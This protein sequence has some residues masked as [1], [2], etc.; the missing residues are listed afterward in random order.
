MDS[1]KRLTRSTSDRMIA[2]VAGGLA[3]YFGLDPVL[4]RVLFV[5]LAIF[6]GGG[7]ILYIAC[8]AL[9]PEG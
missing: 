9:I 1:G 5:A 6:G 4:V 8:W 7:I 2:G 3:D